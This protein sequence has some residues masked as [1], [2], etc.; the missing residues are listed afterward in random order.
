MP[1]IS[2]RDY[3]VISLRSRPTHRNPC[4]T[5]RSCQELCRR[6]GSAFVLCAND[7]E[8]RKNGVGEEFGSGAPDRYLVRAVDRHPTRSTESNTWNIDPISLKG[9]GGN[10]L[11]LSLLNTHM[12]EIVI[13]SAI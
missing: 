8:S 9:H 7:L 12:G 13:H 6:N 5:E 11:T 1:L 4:R 3:V 2:C 10:M